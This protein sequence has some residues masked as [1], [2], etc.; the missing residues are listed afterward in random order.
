MSRI[1]KFIRTKQGIV[2]VVSVVLI[3][4]G[5]VLKCILAHA[6][7]LLLSLL[8]VVSIVMLVINRRVVK[9]IRTQ[10]ADFFSAD[11]KRN[12]DCLVIGDMLDAKSFLAADLNYIQIAAPK[13]G[14]LSDYEIIR[15]A[16]SILKDNGI[17]YIPFRKKYID[18]K[19][20]VFDYPIL[21]P[22]TLEKYHCKRE[23]RKIS[24][25]LLFNFRNA[26][27]LLIGKSRKHGNVRSGLDSRIDDFCRIRGYEVKYIEY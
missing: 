10:Y 6:L 3:I 13:R 19:L 18:N 15:H 11:G 17:I 22:I 26:I 7:F 4:S 8:G 12:I 14:F 9:M 16:H 2:Y 21:H 1:L 23:L 20:S 5:I 25:P 27:L 24:Y